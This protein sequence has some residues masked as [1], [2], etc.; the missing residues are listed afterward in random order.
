MC[1]LPVCTYKWVF[2]RTSTSRRGKGHRPFIM[3]GILRAASR[4]RLCKALYAGDPIMALSKSIISEKVISLTPQ[5]RQLG[6]SRLALFGSYARGEATLDSDVDLLVEFEPGRK[7]FAGLV[8][9]AELL[10]TVLGR[11][12]DA[13]TA[14]SLSPYIGP[15]ILAEAVDVLRAA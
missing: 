15:K 8:S 6:V 11:R 12:V 13:V 14:E 2:Y 4:S 10:E 5:L 7:S 9:L 3:R 1:R